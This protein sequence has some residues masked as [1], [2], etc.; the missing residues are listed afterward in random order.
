MFTRHVCIVTTYYNTVVV[1][2]EYASTGY[3]C[4]SCSWSADQGQLLFPWSPVAHE[5][6]VSRDGVRPSRPAS[7]RS[8]LLAQAES[9]I[10]TIILILYYT[11]LLIL[12]YTILLI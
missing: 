4:Q 10:Y 11:I 5:N 12:Y 8:T 6:L 7:A 2:A 3:G 1:V 9:A